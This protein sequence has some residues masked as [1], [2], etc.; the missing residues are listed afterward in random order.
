MVSNRS[1]T[2]IKV[3]TETRDRVKRLKTGGESC[4][5]LLQ[6]M[7]EQYEPAMYTE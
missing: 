4:D 5:E 1:R 3:S 2:S 7:A 6:K